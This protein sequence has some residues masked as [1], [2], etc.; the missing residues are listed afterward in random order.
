MKERLINLGEIPIIKLRPLKLDRNPFK[1]EDI[2]YFEKRKER[3]IDA[4]FRAAVYKKYKQL[5]PNCGESLHNGEL[6]ELHHIIPTKSK[7]KY[8][9]KNIVPLHQI[10]HQQVTYGDQTLE[11]FKT[12]K[13]KNEEK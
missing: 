9:L 11:R 10:C 4:K 3:L 7:G 13:S 5:C 1:K 12:I 6:V 8:N 2:E